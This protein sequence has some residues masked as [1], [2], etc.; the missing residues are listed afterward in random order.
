MFC[1]S[2]DVLSGN[3]PEGTVHLGVLQEWFGIH[4]WNSREVALLITVLVVMLPLV[5]LPRVGQ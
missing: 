3:Q 2:A 1:L 5:L 4:W